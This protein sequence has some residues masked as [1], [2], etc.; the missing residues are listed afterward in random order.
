MAHTLPH[1]VG[2]SGMSAM[3]F[4]GISHLITD[5][6]ALIAREEDGQI[7]IRKLI[8]YLSADRSYEL[9]LLFQH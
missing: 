6:R 7:S 5:P 9:A 4:L 8:A 2:S 1:S 3:V